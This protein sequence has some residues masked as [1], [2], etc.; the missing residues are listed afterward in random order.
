MRSLTRFAVLFSLALM[1]GAQEAGLTGMY[2]NCPDFSGQVT[3]RTDQ[4]VDYTWASG[5]GISGIGATNYSVLWRGQ[6][7]PKFSEIYTFTTTSDDGVT[8]TIDG[9]TIINNWT[10]HSAV[11]NSGT[12]TLVAGRRYDLQL[13]YFQATGSARIKLA[14][15]S[16][17]T[18]LALVPAGALTPLP[19]QGGLAV[20]TVIESYT[21]PA[22]C[23]GASSEATSALSAKIGTTSITVTRDSKRKWYASNTAS[24]P[25]G[26]IL[27]PT[28]STPVTVSA[29]VQ[30]VTSSVTS[31][32][33]W[34]KLNLA[35]LPYGLDTIYI[36]P[37]DKL[38]LAAH[39]TGSQAQ[40][41]TKFNGT[42]FNPVLSGPTTSVWQV[43]FPTVGTYD[44]RA[45]IAGVDSGRL[46]VIAVGVDLTAPIADQIGFLRQKDLAITPSVAVA[47]E[48]VFTANDPDLF[49][50]N[51]LK[52]VATGVQLGLQPF[53]FG[54]RVLQARLGSNDGPIIAQRPLDVFTLE[55]SAMQWIAVVNT[56][57]DGTALCQAYMTMRPLVP[58]LV[59]NLRTFVSGVT[60]DDSLTQRTV[61]TSAFVPNTETSAGV[62][63]YRLLRAPAGHAN[64]C[65]A[66]V[67]TQNGVR[68]SR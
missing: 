34:T 1:G 14:W 26:I 18:P 40:L 36:R 2:F 29:T 67:V 9:K 61:P 21:S 33:N 54:N 12:I 24:G 15:K 64:L 43:A 49:Q 58:N 8:L 41:D 55:S 5:P 22:W 56:Y 50:V 32:L 57:P 48:L 16:T 28:A 30:G 39:G 53:A 66:F 68:V 45:R 27:T 65:H 60:F 4:T 6:I 42:T 19:P 37:G 38:L 35:S 51:Y 11:D 63:T 52:D 47:Q 46:K 3:T 31:N 10:A 62:Y 20:D 59:L 25:L 17:S 23:E 7:T 13:R 44:V